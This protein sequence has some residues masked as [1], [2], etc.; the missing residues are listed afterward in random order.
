MIQLRCYPCRD[1]IWW[2][3][4]LR[5]ISILGHRGDR[6]TIDQEFI[7]DLLYHRSMRGIHR[8]IPLRNFYLILCARIGSDML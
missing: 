4:S 1:V 3:D 8:K 7:F 5:T 2:I 6:L